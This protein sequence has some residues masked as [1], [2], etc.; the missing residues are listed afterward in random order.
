MLLIAVEFTPSFALYI[1]QSFNTG[2]WHTVQQYDDV[3]EVWIAAAE[4]CSTQGCIATSI[5]QHSAYLPAVLD[6][7]P[8]K[9][10]PVDSLLYLNTNGSQHPSI[11]PPVDPISRNLLLFAQLLNGVAAQRDFIQAWPTI[12]PGDTEMPDYP[13]GRAAIASMLRQLTEISACVP[14]LPTTSTSSVEAMALQPLPKP[15]KLVSMLRSAALVSK[16]A[17]LT[18]S[19][20]TDILGHVDPEMPMAVQALW[21]IMKYIASSILRAITEAAGTSTS[22]NSR[23]EEQTLA[24]SLCE[25]LVATLRQALKESQ[26]AMQRQACLTVLSTVLPVMSPEL[27]R[28][29]VKRLGKKCMAGPAVAKLRSYRIVCVLSSCALSEVWHSRYLHIVVMTRVQHG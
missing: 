14:V 20:K 1:W 9:T 2:L 11:L 27:M 8:L 19:V 22:T 23:R 16:L 21:Y 4:V 26:A 12:E 5:G 10:F 3:L 15:S 7:D 25:H 29:E 13:E 28:N 6:V 17:T 18:F 24:A